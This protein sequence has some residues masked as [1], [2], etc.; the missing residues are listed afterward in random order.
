M[1][2]SCRTLVQLLF[3][4]LSEMFSIHGLVW[5]WT[6]CRSFIPISSNN[7]YSCSCT[8]N[9]ATTA[10]GCSQGSFGCC[11]ESD[12]DPGI[13]LIFQPLD[14]EPSTAH[15]ILKHHKISR[16][17]SNWD[18]V[19]ISFSYLSRF[20]LPVGKKNRRSSIYTHLSD[21]SEFYPF[22][23]SICYHYA[24][25]GRIKDGNWSGKMRVE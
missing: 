19:T 4:L 3:P 6:K 16:S 13:S 10:F 14:L 2:G 15:K 8:G 12:E 5:V 1:V 17:T 18:L 21:L 22:S 23:N 11:S 25:V 20:T 9:R 7:K 24:I